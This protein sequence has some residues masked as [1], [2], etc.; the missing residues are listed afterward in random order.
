MVSCRTGFP[1]NQWR[2]GS[3]SRVYSRDNSGHNPDK[4]K[5][6]NYTP[7]NLQ[8]S[9][10]GYKDREWIQRQGIQFPRSDGQTYWRL[11]TVRLQQIKEL[12]KINTEKVKVI[13]YCSSESSTYMMESSHLKQYWM[14]KVHLIIV[15]NLLMF[16]H[17][18]VIP[19]R[20]ED[21]IYETHF[22]NYERPNS[23][24]IFNLGIL[25]LLKKKI[26]LPWTKCEK[27]LLPS[28]FLSEW[29]TFYFFTET[30]TFVEQKYVSVITKLKRTFAVHG[31]HNV[32]ISDKSPQ[33]AST[34]FW[35]F[36]ADFTH[37][38]TM[39]IFEAR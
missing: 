34:K 23:S 36:D 25:H 2:K 18:V 7:I 38:A 24:F 27:S 9:S 20:V 22:G 31:I 11:S 15:K 21:W 13:E 33:F 6:S 16:N 4:V 26:V 32:V 37:T 30:L 10:V 12:E 3:K 28:S 8:H 17:R 39:D 29:Q 5:S 14:K 19:T 35:N 1:L